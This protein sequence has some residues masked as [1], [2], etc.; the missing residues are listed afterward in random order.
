MLSLLGI[1]VNHCSNLLAEEEAQ[2]KLYHIK[3]IKLKLNISHFLN[4][5][6]I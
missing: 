2:Q 3:K 6:I 4:I 1:F 5:I